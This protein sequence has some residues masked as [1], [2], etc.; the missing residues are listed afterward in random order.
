MMVKLHAQEYDFPLQS[1]PGPTY[2]SSPALDVMDV[3][4]CHWADHEDFQL[5]NH[6]EV[7]G[8]SADEPSVASQQPCAISEDPIVEVTVADEEGLK[9]DLKQPEE[10]PVIVGK[11]IENGTPVDGSHLLGLLRQ[12]KSVEDPAKAANQKKGANKIPAV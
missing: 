3:E 10:E 1:P 6:C 5:P 8:S 7:D 2:V 9:T 11:L 12:L 4:S